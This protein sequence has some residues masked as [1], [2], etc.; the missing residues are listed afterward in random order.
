[1]ENDSLSQQK[2][3][4]DKAEREQLEEIV[5]GMRERVED[6]VRFQLTQNGLDEKPDD[7]DA[8]NDDISSLVEAIELEAVDG[9]DWEKGLEQY[10]TSVGYTI[11]NR[12]AAL[13]CMEVRGFIDEEVTVFK[14][15]GL[16]PAA[17]TLVHEEFLLEDEA[18]LEAYHRACDALAAEIEIL[19]DRSS[20]YSLVDPDDDTFGE[21]CGMLDEIPDAVWRADDVLGWVYEYYNR[22]VVEALD[23]KNTLEPEDVGPANQFYTPHWVVRMLAD[24]SL[25]KL[26]LEATGKESSVPAPEELSP[27]ERKER[28][29][30]PEDAP[31]VS[32]LCTYL[33]P[34]EEDQ[35]A[36]SFDHP[37]E[38]QVIDPACGSGHFLL[39]AFDILERIWW[40]ETDLDRGEIPAK[41]LEHNLY[42]VDIDLRSCQ[43][44]AFNLYL[45]ART[46]AEAEDNASFEMPNLGIVCA[47]ARVAEVETAV[48]VLDQITG[49]E[50][51]VRE[52]IG[53]VIEEFQTT[54]ALGSLLDVQG[55]L[56]EE[57][58]SGQSDVLEWGGE[59]PQTLHEFLKRLR[60]AVEEQ[61]ADSFGEQNLRSFLHLLVVLTQDY[62]VA[63]MNPPYGSKGRMPNDVKSYVEVHYDYTTEYYINFFETCGRLVQTSGR[64]GMLVPRSFMFLKSFQNFREDFIG[65]RGSFDFLAEYG[66]DILDNA[67]VRTAGTVLRSDGEGN[68]KGTFIRLD[69]VEKGEKEQSFLHAAFVSESEN[70]VRRRFTR[71]VSEFEFVPGS[72]LTYWVSQD[73]RKLYDSNVVLDAPNAG[74]DK[75]SVGNI[76]VGLQT[77]NDG[78]FTQ[79][80]WEDEG[81]NWVPLAKGGE[82]SWL[83]PRIRKTVL[84]GDNGTEVTR[85]SGSYPRNTAYYYREGNTFNRVKESGRRFGYLH[86]QSVF[87]DKGPVIFADV[88]QWTVL[89][90]TNSRLFTYLMLA[91]TT[92]RMWEV[93]QVSKIPW[94][95]ELEEI[96][97][98]KSLSKEAVG[99]LVS[100]RQYDFVSPHYNGP[101]LLD[102]LGVNDS[103]PQYD[104][105]HRGLRE[106]LDLN[107]PVDTVDR[108]ASLEEFGMT[109][110]RHFERIE[111]DLQSC[112][113][114]IDE[115][116][117]D[118]FDIT[119]EQRETILQEIALRTN[120]DPREREEHDPESITEPSDEFSEMVKDLLLHLTLRIVHEDDDGIVPLSDVD[121]EDDLLTRLEDEFERIFGEH[122]DERL[123]EVD[124]LL[125]SQTADEEAYPNLREW[126]ESDLFDYHVSTFDRTPILWRFTTERLVS[127]PEGEGFACLVDYHQLDANVFDRLQNRYLEPRKALLRERRSAANRRRGDDSLSASERAA[128]TEEYARCESGLEQIGVFEDRLAELAQPAARDWPEENQTLAE[129]AAEQ[130]AAFRKRTATRLNA[131]DT[132]AALD[133]TDMADLFSPTFYETVQE[134]REEWLDAL[135][136]LETAFET[137]A[138]DGSEPVEAHL[139][140]LFEYYDDLVGS[141]HY[142]SNG[143]LFMTYYFDKFEDPEQTQ[144]GDKGISERQRLLSKLASDLDDYQELANEIADACDEIAADIPSDWSDR[145]L[146]EITTAGYQP[147]H[148]HGVEINITPLAQAEIVPKT[149][150]DNVL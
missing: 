35:Q 150:D 2:V 69:D 139:Y 141:T 77:G 143:I 30:T 43:L 146:S 51:G 59:G 22:P 24:N 48:D 76:K 128:A 81:A 84:W 133:D 122:A 8:L 134:N 107:D 53:E 79:A 62:D 71:P 147:N 72:P 56:A 109:A 126:L 130:V 132:L 116:I 49:D 37:S 102:V 31:D 7:T 131:L 118:S 87:G 29:V 148:K 23:A 9:D 120:E 149:V 80:F 38:L 113:D 95:K 75:S 67:T 127:D 33:I 136:A 45:K 25:G 142:A 112:A 100:K 82:D 99:Y 74:L 3:Q 105:P 28:L 32:S 73:L 65:G 40:A 68:D 5:A 140:D 138:E 137:Y 115:A 14:E 124:Q 39:Y 66:I 111:S 27:E 97:E 91:Q 83:L 104:H 1:M 93:G 94:R 15:N 20:A 17:E 123:A 125:G 52:A 96:D 46:R 92:E 110:A 47:D 106:D 19:F 135:D 60:A 57:F 101:V 145:A 61:T 16:T 6:N 78:R 117:F 42:G 13:R 58:E 41:V 108:S 12:L 89:S 121:S 54:E 64:I 129:A 50:T 85:Y 10:I 88:D 114:A 11:V 119:D 86:P 103:L 26:Y 55:T 4:L 18:I 63:L 44:S 36:P 34:D 21:L 144:I 98:L 70:G 90:F